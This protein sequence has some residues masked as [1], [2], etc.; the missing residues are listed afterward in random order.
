MSVG[1]LVVC[2]VGLALAAVNGAT[3]RRLW[4]CP[5][6]ERS[7]KIAQTVLIWIVPGSFFAVRAVLGEQRARRAI[8]AGDPTS[9]NPGGLG[10]YESVETHAHHWGGGGEGFGG[11]GDG[12]I[13]GGG[14]AG[15]GTY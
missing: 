4:A 15:G 11:G 14:D 12:G 1:S 6:F 2:G 5:I 7:Q 8:G 10:G 13:G 3:T 9:H